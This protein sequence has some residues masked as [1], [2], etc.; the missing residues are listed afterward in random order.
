MR[1]IQ[2]KL[3]RTIVSLSLFIPFNLYGSGLFNPDQE[4]LSRA[5]AKE[6]YPCVVSLLCLSEVRDDSNATGVI[7]EIDGRLV[8]LTNRHVVQPEE[9]LWIDTS[10]FDGLDGLDQ[11]LATHLVQED[12]RY[13]D[14]EVEPNNLADIALVFFVNP[15]LLRQQLDQLGIHPATLSDFMT[16]N[17]KV[18]ETHLVGCSEMERMFST[19]GFFGMRPLFKDAVDQKKNILGELEK[20]A[21]EMVEQTKEIGGAFT[22]DRYAEIS[23]LVREIQLQIATLER[24]SVFE[25]IDMEFGEI[26]GFA[27]AGDSGGGVFHEGKLWGLLFQGNHHG[28]K[29]VTFAQSLQPF[30]EWFYRQIRDMPA[31]GECAIEDTLRFE[32]IRM[33]TRANKES[34]RL[35]EK[36]LAKQKKQIEELERLKEELTRTRDRANEARKGSIWSNIWKSLWG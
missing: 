9:K 21:Q 28:G 34:D 12:Y 16:G 1:T 11:P 33:K 23:N 25:S 26:P 19:A 13:P 17:E 32:Q 30:R 14:I 35:I 15:V 27:I 22:M 36:K 18:I 8:L 2:K 7:T 31:R 6:L 4:D 20:L 24:Y 10:L 3:L 29:I 5:K